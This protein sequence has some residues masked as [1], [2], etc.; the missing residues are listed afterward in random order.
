MCMLCASCVFA[1]CVMCMGARILALLEGSRMKRKLECSRR[2]EGGER[3]GEQRKEKGQSLSRKGEEEIS[4]CGNSGN[5]PIP[6]KC[7]QIWD[8]SAT[9]IC[10]LAIVTGFGAG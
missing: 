5:Q 8:S 9:L 7:L 10:L 4:L 3:E 2:M 1:V 6:Q